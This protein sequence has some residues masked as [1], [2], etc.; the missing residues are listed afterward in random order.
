MDIFLCV[1]NPL[2]REKSRRID[3][4]TSVLSLKVTELHIYINSACFIAQT[5]MSRECGHIELAD[6]T[7]STDYHKT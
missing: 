3:K 6:S 7:D 5:I 1:F 2:L 4:S